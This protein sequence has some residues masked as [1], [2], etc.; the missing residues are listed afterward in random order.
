M[1]TILQPINFGVQWEVAEFVRADNVIRFQPGVQP[2]LSPRPA[3]GA[4]GVHK[5]DYGH[6]LLVL[7]SLKICLGHGEAMPT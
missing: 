7:V 2:F 5:H 3:N 4:A 6:Q 1:L